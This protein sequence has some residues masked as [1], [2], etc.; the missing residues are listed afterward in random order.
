MVMAEDLEQQLI[1]LQEE[2][3]RLQEGA[4]QVESCL[5]QRIVELESSLRR[6]QQE[7]DCVASERNR[8]QVSWPFVGRVT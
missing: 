5:E 8:L 6:L 2:F 7:Y 3:Q 1:S 4:A